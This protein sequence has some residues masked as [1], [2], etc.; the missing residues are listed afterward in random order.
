MFDDKYDKILFDH[1][2]LVILDYYE[3]CKLRCTQSYIRGYDNYQQLKIIESDITN[4]LFFNIVIPNNNVN[5]G[6]PQYKSIMYIFKNY[7]VNFPIFPFCKGQSLIDKVGT[8][9]MTKHD[10][11]M[12]IL[13]TI[14][15]LNFYLPDNKNNPNNIPITRIYKNHPEYFMSENDKNITEI[16][17]TINKD[18]EQITISKETINQENKKIVEKKEELDKLIIENDK[19]TKNKQNEL[20]KLILE[21]QQ[22]IDYYKNLEQQIIEVNKEKEIIKE[23]KRK[24]AIVK[25]K[26]AQIK[27][28]LDEEKFKLEL[29]KD[30]IND[31]N[32]DDFINSNLN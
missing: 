5:N 2:D 16:L 27:R 10:F 30:R 13:F 9:I 8:I 12:D 24:I 11:R 14:K 28:N 32:V 4:K 18:K 26:M 19:I 1:T 17:E 15:Y 22:K 20:D 31:I 21:N 6:S 23:E 29:E 3:E 25:E 7:F